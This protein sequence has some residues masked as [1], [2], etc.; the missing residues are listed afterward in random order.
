MLLSQRR[1]KFQF[2]PEGDKLQPIPIG[3]L[4]EIDAHILIFIADAAHLFMM[5]VGGFD[6]FYCE[7]QME[8]SFSQ[9]VFFCPVVKVRQFKLKIRLSVTEVY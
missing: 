1:S 3:I 8:F 5:R 7:C 4:Y 2:L 9:V 6:I